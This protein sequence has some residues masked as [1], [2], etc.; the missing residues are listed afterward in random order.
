MGAYQ[1][2]REDTVARLARIDSAGWQRTGRHE[3]FG[4][5]TL[6]EQASYFAA[7][8]LTHLRQLEQLRRAAEA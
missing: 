2:A 5:V 8:E 6:I 3:E 4:R 1:S 7:H